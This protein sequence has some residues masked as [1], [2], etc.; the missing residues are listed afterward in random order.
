MSNVTAER[1]NSNRKPRPQ[2]RRS[3]RVFRGNGRHV[4]LFTVGHEQTGYY[5]EAIPADFGTGFK[6]EK[7]ACDG[8]ELYQ[9]NL[10]PDAGTN[11]CTCKGHSYRGRCKHV[12]ALAVL[13][14]AGRI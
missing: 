1:T 13:R 7:F 10:D 14:K 4:L 6:L 5:L 11:T 2:P 8:G 3:V 9:V 12:E